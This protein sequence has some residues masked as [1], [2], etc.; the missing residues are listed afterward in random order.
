MTPLVIGLAAVVMVIL[1]AVVIGM[2][3]VRNEERADLADREEDG[4]RTERVPGKTRGRQT[5][6]WRQAGQQPGPRRPPGRV[7]ERSRQRRASA[8]EY[9]E[10][11]GRG[12]DRGYAAADHGQDDRRHDVAGR[13]ARGHGGRDE[14]ARP[15]QLQD[16]LPQVRA[17]QPRGRRNDDGDWPSTEWDK[18][19]D[20]DYWK[21][22]AS[23]KPLTT[24]A[25]TA[26]PAQQPHPGPAAP[27]G[28]VAGHADQV[29][30]AGM[31]P[32]RGP[33]L[34]RGQETRRSQEPRREAARPPGRGTLEPAA[35]AGGQ[36]F[37]AAPTA[38]RFPEYG[39][40]EPVL[41]GP[42]HPEQRRAE[43]ARPQAAP[44]GL[45]SPG[46]RP[47]G[48]RAA[49]P[50]PYDDDP[51]T[52]PSFPKI[53]TSDSRSYGSGRPSVPAEQAAYGAPTAQFASYGA[54]SYATAGSGPADGRA[55]NG[56]DRGF[57]ASSATTAPHSYGRAA[58]PPAASSPANGHHPAGYAAGAGS[59]APAGGHHSAGYA[60]GPPAA[61]HQLAGP[62]PARPLQ[63]VPPPAGNPYGSYV[64]AELPGYADNPTAVYPRGQAARDYP[65]YS[66]GPANGNAGPAYSYDLPLSDSAP[67]L[68]QPASWYPDVPVMAPAPSPVAPAPVPH[69][70]RYPHGEISGQ[71]NGNGQRSSSGYAPGPYSDGHYDVPGYPPGGYSAQ[72]A[73]PAYPPLG[74][75]S[76]GQ[77]DAAGYLPPDFYRGDE[78]GGQHR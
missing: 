12:E 39:G 68:G 60:A 25:R 31:E 43:Q 33:D 67:P 40:Q 2:R 51:L 29:T 62:P 3:Y 69:P 20:A 24:T 73:A 75:D 37:L 59:G 72:P 9:D 55:A 61:P 47:A 14:P 6:E 36:D 13:A 63:A 74:A 16:D 53:V 77:L 22:V 7:P 64:S 32:R 49:A 30:G 15:Q 44:P 17:R 48:Q 41:P 21:E 35:A 76:A 52:S 27:P 56:Y 42:G 54:A 5:P 50:M 70:D 26:Q 78:Y 10:R 71:D 23:D 58:Q 19:S 34:R 45:A 46:T 57:A 38:V 28:D 1:I 4:G 18:L 11:P 65:G 8:P 66:A